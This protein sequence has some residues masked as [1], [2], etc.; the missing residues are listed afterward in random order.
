MRKQSP[1]I[2]ACHMPGTVVGCHLL[3]LGLCLARGVVLQLFV[4]TY[5]RLLSAFWHFYNQCLLNSF[6][7]VIWL[8]C[9]SKF[10][11][12]KALSSRSSVNLN[13]V[14]D[15]IAFMML[16][17]SIGGGSLASKWPA[18]ARHYKAAVSVTVHN[19]VAHEVYNAMG[20]RKEPPA[21][22]GYATC[23]VM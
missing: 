20:K 17:T 1:I 14:N 8:E 21:C 19:I 11:L 12:E 23:H 6:R 2:E 10:S 5:H 7:Q 18:R 22:S 3:C 13:G 15:T 9:E 16:H 4:Q